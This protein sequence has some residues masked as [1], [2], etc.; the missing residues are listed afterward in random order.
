MTRLDDRKWKLC[1]IT[2]SIHI[3]GCYSRMAMEDFMLL[4]YSKQIPFAS[5]IS[6]S[7]DCQ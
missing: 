5:I 4:E 2:D 6:N 7:T 3:M 1:Y